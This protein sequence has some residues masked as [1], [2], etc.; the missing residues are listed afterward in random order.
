M[1]F[2][3]RLSFSLFRLNGLSRPGGIC[4]HVGTFIDRMMNEK[5]Q[6]QVRR[7]LKDVTQP[8][9][10]C[11]AGL[12]ASIDPK[13]MDIIMKGVSSAVKKHL[14]FPNSPHVMALGSEKDVINAAAIE[15]ARAND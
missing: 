2:N 9:L 3:A 11:E 1:A 6:G 12:D 14:F 8:V 7:K 13:S 15:F 5:L 4:P 10:I